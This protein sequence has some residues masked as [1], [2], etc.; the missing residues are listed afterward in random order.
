MNLSDE[1]NL[2]PKLKNGDIVLNQFMHDLWVYR[3][4]KIRLWDNPNEWHEESPEDVT[5]NCKE[6]F[7]IIGHESTHK[8]L[9]DE[10]KARGGPND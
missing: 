7:K 3:D 1:D 2:V 8:E 10:I 4:G 5:W 6:G 9:M